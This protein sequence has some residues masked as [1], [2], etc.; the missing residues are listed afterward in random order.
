MQLSLTSLALFVGVALA[1][2]LAPVVYKELET[3]QG[4]LI[5]DNCTTYASVNAGTVCIHVPYD[6]TSF[7]EVQLGET[8]L[9]IAAK[10]NSFSLTQFFKWNPDV[11][12]TC[13]SLR[14]YV[15]V[16]IATLW[17]SFVPPLIQYPPGAIVNATSTPV[18]I[19]PQITA[20]C[21]TFQLVGEGTTVDQILI[22]HGIDIQQFVLWNAMVQVQNPVVWRDYFVCVEV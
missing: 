22:Q 8:C 21:K 15:P 13:I 12:Q 17:Y 20:F 10:F 11:G 16:C 19:M 6:C 5:P 2:P 7:Y 1:N 18:P 4:P 9:S 3:R 14:A